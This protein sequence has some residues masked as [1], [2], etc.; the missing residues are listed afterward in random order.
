MGPGGYNFTSA[1]IQV[2]ISAD[3]TING[4][5]RT[6]LPAR[7][8]GF[9]YTIEASCPSCPNATSA[10]ITDVGFGDVYLC[11]GWVTLQKR[12]PEL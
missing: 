6:L 10:I 4:T 11:S 9:G 1:P 5:W 12:Y 2:V 7:P 8:P 3:P